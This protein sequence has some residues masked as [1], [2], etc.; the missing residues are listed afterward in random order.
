[1][2][3]T[4]INK[5]IIDSHFTWIVVSLFVMGTAFYILPPGHMQPGHYLAV[6]I[7]LIS[8]SFIRL[9]SLNLG[10]KWLLVF[11]VY[12]TAL[13]TYYYFD[14]R[15]V[16]FFVSILFWCYNIALF[17]ALSH[18][19]TYSEK[20]R[21]ALP[22]VFL[23]CTFSLFV[24]WAVGYSRDDMVFEQ[25]YL[26]QFNDPNQMGYWLI[27]SFLSFYFLVKKGVLLNRYFQ[28]CF[29]CLVV[30]LI[31]TT[32]SRSALIGLIPLTA[33]F[34]WF[35]FGKYKLTIAKVLLII[36][37][38]VSIFGVFKFSKGV[39]ENP[40][41]QVL[42]KDKKNKKNFDTPLDRLLATDWHEEASIRGYFRPIK[43]PQYLLFGA[44]HGQESRFNSIRE[45]HSSFLSVFFYYGIVGLVLF[46]AFLYQIF[47][48]LSLPEA[49]MLS[50]P[51]VYGLFTYGF[52]TPI[53]WVLMAIVVATR[54]M[55][56]KAFESPSKQ[57]SNAT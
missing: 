23:I 30:T 1:M 24:L 51:F 43:H 14:L 15:N 32:E 34:I 28:L 55:V 20:A 11:G 9:N 52:R 18:L 57:V 46:M 19:L 3:F 7:V 39:S 50:A 53:F 33:G 35:N 16:E 21:I 5:K 42:H 25:R 38:I 22:Y 10:D 17:I 12:V 45:I 2:A 6:I 31:V 26:G 27:C 37:V 41:A 47:R 8:A 13:N 56:L 40:H 54:P 36:M 44:G 29:L 48:R 4:R 49:L